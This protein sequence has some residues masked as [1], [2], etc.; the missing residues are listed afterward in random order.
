MLFLLFQSATVMPDLIGD[1]EPW[2]PDQV[3]H[4]KKSLDKAKL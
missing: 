3:G 2:M 1:P 4:D